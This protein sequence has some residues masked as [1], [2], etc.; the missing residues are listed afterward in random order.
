[1]R[2]ERPG[3]DVDRVA[4]E[5][6]HERH[7]GCEQAVAEI[8]GRARAVAEIVVVD[9]LGEALRDRLEVASGEPAVRRKPFREDAERPALVGQPGSF[10]AT[11]PPMFA[12]GSFFA[13]IVMPSASDAVSRTIS[14]TDRSA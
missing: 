12:S 4:A 7:S 6:L 8:R 2:Q 13:L 5:R 14:A 3:V 1:M 10:I 9:G 11:Q